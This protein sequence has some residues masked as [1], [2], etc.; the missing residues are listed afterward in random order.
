MKCKTIPFVDGFSFDYLK[1]E[2][3]KKTSYENKT[4][5]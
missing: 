3:E 2:F 5:M 4:F 1:L